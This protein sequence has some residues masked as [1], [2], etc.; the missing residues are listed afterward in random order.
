MEHI[1]S[2][3][4]KIQ[5]S[6]PDYQAGI[7]EA[8]V[9]NTKYSNLLWKEITQ[10]TEQ[11][12]KLYTLSEINKRLTI[13][14]TRQAY[15]TF[16]KDPNRYRPSAEALCRRIVKETEL[17]QISTLVDLINLVSIKSGFSIGGFDADKID[18]NLTLGI[19]HKE[20]IFNAIGRG[21]LNIDGLPVYRDKKGPIGTP[22]SDEIRTQLSIDTQ[23]ILIII[24][25]YSCANLL[26]ETIQYTIRLLTD[27]ADA[28]NITY[29]IIPWPSSIYTSKVK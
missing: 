6:C 10:E 9:H 14:A 25:S 24:N 13:Q 20:E 22:T 12:K 26:P 11:I 2:I 5:N 27:Y 7:I 17:Y 19:G 16:G 4:D 18:G 8:H 1:I 23:N 28:T 29:K 15:K 21:L 3:S